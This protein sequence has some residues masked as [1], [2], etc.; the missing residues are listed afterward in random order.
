MNLSD[1]KKAVDN[2]IERAADHGENPDGIPV[3]LQIDGVEGTTEDY[4]CA[5]DVTL[6]YD[7]NAQASGC[8][9][10]AWNEQHKNI[11]QVLTDAGYKTMSGAD[12]VLS[13]IAAVSDGKAKQ[14]CSGYGVFP[15]G[16]KCGGCGDCR[17]APPQQ[18]GREGE[19][20]QISW[21]DFKT[22]CVCHRYNVPDDCT[23]AINKSEKCAI[24]VC[25]CW[26][27]L[28]NAPAEHSIEATHNIATQP[29]WL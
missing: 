15:D 25:P 4:V 7:G 10:Q 29:S 18:Q 20:R 14:L 24:D 17:P 28:A 23:A 13:A 8:V 27:Q 26:R 19:K 2:A 21:K 12:N 16:A 11:E 9:L 1:L 22:F 3:T 6:H 5:E